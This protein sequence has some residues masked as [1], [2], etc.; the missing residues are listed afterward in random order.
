MAAI[1][2]FLYVGGDLEGGA[3]R[4][5]RLKLDLRYAEEVNAVQSAS[6]DGDELAVDELYV[7]INCQREAVSGMVPGM[8]TVDGDLFLEAG[9]ARFV[10]RLPRELRGRIISGHVAFQTSGGETTLTTDGTP[11]CTAR[12]ETLSSFWTR[13]FDAIDTDTTVW[14]TRTLPDGSSRVEKFFWDSAELKDMEYPIFDITACSGVGILHYTPSDGGFYRKVP[15]ETVLS[16]VIGGAVPYSVDSQ[17]KDISV[18]GWLPIQSARENVHYLML[19]SG[20]VIRRNENLDLF[21]TLP[22]ET[23]A[24]LTN[25][26]IYVG[27]SMDYGRRKRYTRVDVEEFD[28]IQTPNDAEIVLY[29]NTESQDYAN[30]KR[31]EFQQAP[32]Y[33]I[34][35]SSG[36][37]VHQA[38]ANFAVVSGVGQLTG[39]Q[40][41]E[42]VSIVS[43]EIS[44]VIRAEKVLAIS[45]IPIINSLNSKSVASRIRDLYQSGNVYQMDIVRTTEA[46][47]DRI[48]FPDASG[49]TVRGYITEMS[50]SLTAIE[51]AECTVVAGYTH[52]HWGNTYQHSILLTGAGV[53]TVPEELAGLEV[54]VVLISGGQGG[55]SGIHGTDAGGT[56]GGPGAPGSGGRILLAEVTLERGAS[57]YYSCGTGGAGGVDAASVTETEDGPA[58]LSAPGQPGRDTVFGQYSTAEGVPSGYGYVDDLS[59]VRYAQ[60]GPDYGVAGGQAMTGRENRDT[61]F[62][63]D[64]ERPWVEVGWG[65]NGGPGTQMWQSGDAGGGAYWSED[66]EHQFDIYAVDFYAFGGLGGGAAVGSVGENGA[67]AVQGSRPGKGGK[68]ADAQA[69]FPAESLP[70]GS[71]GSG[72]HGGGEGGLG[73]A[74]RVRDFGSNAM[75]Q[76]RPGV[77]NTGG[78]GSAG[79]PGQPGCIIIYY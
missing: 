54:R 46:P 14:Y 18:S 15:L 6:L 73:G 52:T 44:P 77:Q 23:G 26:D 27:G 79:Q 33:G 12:T 70:L 17:V 71:G 50:S 28:Y 38:T 31:I 10:P 59:G 68:G 64:T 20:I 34:T 76:D 72:G 22:K 78:S 9:G 2:A 32:I 29:D 49:E 21:F 65:I 40:Y 13:V 56:G 1:P 30:R 35:A 11:F 57:I 5:W 58:Y 47:G 61:L 36:L 63:T 74:L 19:T 67:D 7:T 4:G 3:V 42:I 55:G 75:W 48:A 62:Y 53:W 8:I 37:T 24:V 39:K 43:E 51:K 66:Y 60:P 16:E 45:G 41:T 69:L 25:D